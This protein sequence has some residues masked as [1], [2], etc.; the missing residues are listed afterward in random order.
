MIADLAPAMATD[1][2]IPNFIIIATNRTSVDRFGDNRELAIALRVCHMLARNPVLQ[3]N[4]GASGAVSSASEGGVSQSYS[5]P[6]YMHQKYG[7]LCS[8]SYGCQLADLIEGNIFSTLTATDQA[9]E[10]LQGEQL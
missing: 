5:V 8:T 10:L 9:G 1:S 2:R 3:R 6:P 7:D 4:G